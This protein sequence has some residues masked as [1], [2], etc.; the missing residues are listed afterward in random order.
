VNDATGPEPLAEVR[1]VVGRRV[2]RLLRILFGVQVVEVAEELV[3]AVHGRQELVPVAEMVLAELAGRVAERLQ[4]LGDRHVLRLQ[5]HRRSRYAHFA[6]A[7]AE[8][9]LAGDERRPPRRAALLAI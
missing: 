5:A 3:E 1:E 6:Q 8:H 2:V 9:A 4:E 7:R